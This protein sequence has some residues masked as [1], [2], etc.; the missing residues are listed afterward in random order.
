[1]MYV[2]V[3]VGFT[4]IIKAADKFTALAK[5]RELAAQQR[6]HAWTLFDRNG[7]MIGGV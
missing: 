4:D 2:Y 3:T 5:A 1:M 7:R 6:A